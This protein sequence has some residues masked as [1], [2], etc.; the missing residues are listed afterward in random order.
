MARVLFK[1]AVWTAKKI[2]KKEKWRVVW[3]DL[4][5]VDVWIL[6]S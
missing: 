2:S 5:K 6:I 1:R 3:I 4:F